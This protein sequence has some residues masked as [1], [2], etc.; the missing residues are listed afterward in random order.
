MFITKSGPGNSLAVDSLRKAKL[1]FWD[2]DG[3]IKETVNLKGEA[4]A[5]LFL[6]YGQE[7][8]VKIRQHHA[9][10]GGVS[11]FEKIPLYLGWAGM[12]QDLESVR[13][14]CKEYSKIVFRKVLE[15]PWVPGAQEL[16]RCNPRQQKYYLVTATPQKEMEA[17]LAALD[18]TVVFK[19]VFG[20]PVKKAD[21]IRRTLEASGMSKELCL[22]IGDSQADKQAASIANIPFLL[23]KHS[24]NSDL[25]EDR[26]I[27]RIANFL[28]L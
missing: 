9:L 28:N 27:I 4:F 21:A 8:M 20:A 26:S 13:R 6:N 15:A 18:L 5:D 17:I 16:L 2:F 1:V 7:L 3:V 19:G 24:D 14:F 22:L 23:R 25:Q 10:H 11:R 12:S